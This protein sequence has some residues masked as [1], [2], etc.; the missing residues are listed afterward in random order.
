MD[1][2][3]RRPRHHRRFRFDAGRHDRDADAPLEVLVEGRAEDDVG[4]GIDLVADAVGRLVDLEEG[5][6]EAAGDVDQH[7]AGAAHGDVVAAADWRSPPRPRRRR[8]SRPP[9][10][11]VPIIALPILGHHRADV[12]E[13]EIDQAGHD[14]E[15]GDP[16]HAG[17][18]HLVRHVEGVAKCGALV[19]DAEQVLIGDDDQRVDELLQLLDAGPRPCACGAAPRSGRAWSTTPTVRTP[20]SRAARAI[21]GAPPVPVPPPIA[22][23]D[24]THMGA[25][26]LLD[27]LLQ[28]FLGG[29]RGRPR[30]ATRRPRPWV[31]ALPSWMR[32]VAERLGERLGLGVA[33]DEFD[34]LE[35]GADHVVDRIAAGAADADPR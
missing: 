10:S 2:A 27:D 24:D 32:R 28:R 13:V 23:G 25:L 18:Q 33:D 1:E 26:E 3:E 4:I 29:G 11:P 31:T 7:P 17:M 19:G 9:A 34:A 21:T 8:G 15:V 22:G 35:I 5:H 12:G 6:V 16:A 30:G 20:C 14:H